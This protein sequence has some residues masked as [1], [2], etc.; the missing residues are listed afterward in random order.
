MSQQPVLFTV[1]LLIVL[2]FAAHKL[3]K[4]GAGEQ[5]EVVSM[6]DPPPVPNEPSPHVLPS[7]I[8]STDVYIPLVTPA[9]EVAVQEQNTD[10][11]RDDYYQGLERLGDTGEGF[12]HCNLALNEASMMFLHRWK[13]RTA[14]SI[15][16]ASP[17]AF[18]L[19]Q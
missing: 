19:A 15:I 13:S 11:E 5:E 1:G 3:V 8:P 4:R 10:S 18:Q 12:H 9:K 16:S 2:A 14:S 17:F 6:V 7:R